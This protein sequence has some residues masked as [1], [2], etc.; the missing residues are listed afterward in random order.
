MSIFIG[1]YPNIFILFYLGGRRGVVCL[2]L[3]LSFI[4]SYYE[5]KDTREISIFFIVITLSSCLWKGASQH[6]QKYKKEL[7]NS[8]SI[9]YLFS[10]IRYGVPGTRM[11]KV[12]II[13]PRTLVKLQL[14]KTFKRQCPIIRT[15]R[16]LK[17][18]N[19][20]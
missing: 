4:V 8:T 13:K 7:I 3:R 17:G 18:G 1:F 19:F 5:W 20:E 10:S 15:V 9:Y 6:P 14:T 12:N 2:R 16:I 11:A